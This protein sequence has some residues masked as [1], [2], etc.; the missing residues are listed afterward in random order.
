MRWK[1]Q[2]CVLRPAS[3]ALFQPLRISFARPMGMIGMRM[4]RVMVMIM[5]VG[6]MIV[7]MVVVIVMMVMVVI[8]VMIVDVPMLTVVMVPVSVTVTMVGIGADALDM[9]VMAGL[10]QPDLRFKADDLLPVLAHAA[11]HVV[12]AGEDLAHPVGKGIQHQGMVVQVLRLQ[13]LDLRM[14]IGHFVG[15]AVDALH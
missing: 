8:M 15:D 10:R 14:G 6:A 1:R 9:V 4:G 7:A 11:V 13:E 2:R 3:R 12:V 5:A